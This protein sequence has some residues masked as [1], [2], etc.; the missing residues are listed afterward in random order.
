MCWCVCRAAA[1]P[2]RDD[3]SDLTRGRG[4]SVH[5]ADCPN[6][7]DLRTEPERIVGMVER[8]IKEY[9]LPGGSVY[10]GT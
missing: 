7:Q 1:T 9:F 3:V 6:A 4:V 2:A 5:R 10:R 8:A